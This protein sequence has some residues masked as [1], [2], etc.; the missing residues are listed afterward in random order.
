MK[1]ALFELIIA[2][3]LLKTW[4]TERVYMQVCPK[5]LVFIWK[6]S[7]WLI[8]RKQRAGNLIPFLVSPVE[9]LLLHCTLT[10]HHWVTLK[11]LKETVLWDTLP[12]L[13]AVV[14]G[15][16]Y[17]LTQFTVSQIYM[18]VSFFV[19][20]W[21]WWVSSSEHWE[22]CTAIVHVF[23]FGVIYV[24]PNVWFIFDEW[25]GFWYACVLLL[26]L[27]SFMGSSSISHF[28]VS[29]FPPIYSYFEIWFYYIL[30]TFT[31]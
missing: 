8:P 17:H 24:I 12:H 11:V 23:L 20:L 25:T 21:N 3:Y 10:L 27:I 18:K 31:E 28:H 15:A 29:F 7:H 13:L 1:A 19:L 14:N 9:M 4:L 16:V 2:Q 30:W 22:T 5:D 26:R 6:I